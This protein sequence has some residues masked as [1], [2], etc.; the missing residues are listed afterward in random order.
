VRK[1]FTAA[2]RSVRSFRVVPRRPAI[3]FILITLLID[4]MSFGLLLPVL[5]ALVGEFTTGRDA[6]TYWYGAMIVTFGLTQFFCAPLLGALSDR[7]G[8]R[9]VLLGSIAGLGS[10]FLLSALATSLT[11]LV[12]ARVLG[13]VL[14]ANFAV[15]NAYVADLTTPENR[16]KS[17][18]LIGAAFGIGYIIGPMVGGLLGSIDIRL[19]F[20]VA[21]GLSAANFLYGLLVVPESL[22]PERRKP[23]QWL[24]ANPISSLRGLAKLRSVGV[25]VAVIAL[26]NLAQFIL[27]STW[28]LFTDFRFG[29]GPRETGL[30]LFAVG[31]MAAL[32]QGGL[33]GWLMR[34]LG[35]R[36]VVLAGLASGAVAYV[37]YGL[38]TTGWVMYVIIVVNLLAFA[39][40]PALGAIVSKAADP[41]EQGLAMGSLT[42]LSALMAVTAPFLGTPLLA[43]VSH[44]PAQD[45][46]IGAPFFLSAALSF[47]AL[48]LAAYHFRRHHAP[49]AAH[50]APAARG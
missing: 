11:G 48:T 33:L 47:V 16:A 45:W 46:R 27:H 28:V 2:D 25:L 26:A 9:P 14:A 17:F 4:V 23:L 37:A 21:A 20:Y 6:Q 50:V 35:E 15:A 42:S 7:Y 31:V 18:G 8:R 34:T 44:L 38:T 40:G 36:R 13:G 12:L 43:I 29:W 24:R 1:T 5:P 32:V 10:M 30:S 49:D 41:T 3:A 19:P 22:P 39:V